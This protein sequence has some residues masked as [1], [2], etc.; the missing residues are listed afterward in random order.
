MATIRKRNGQWQ[1]QVR[2]QGHSAV[3]NT[4]RQYKDAEAW[5]LETE[6]KLK[7]HGMPVSRKELEGVTLGELIER[8]RDQCLQ[9]K[10]SGENEKIV[11]NAFLA[12]EANL[13]RKSLATIS[14]QDFAKYRDERLR[15]VKPSTLRR[16]LN[17]LRHMFKVARNE[18]RLPADDPLQGLWLPAEP[19]HRERRLHEGEQARL[20]EAAQGCRGLRQKALWPMLILLALQT[21][22]RRGEI[23]GLRWEDVDFEKRTIVVRHSK[24]GKT[25]TLPMSAYMQPSFIAFGIFA[26]GGPIHSLW[27]SKRGERIDPMTSSAFE[28][29]W[30][31]LTKR[32][33]IQGLTFHD[34]RHEAACRFDEA[35]L[36]HSE[37]QYMLGHSHRDMTSR[38]V[39]ADLERIRA[40]LD[41]GWNTHL[42]QMKVYEEEQRR[43]EEQLVERFPSDDTPGYAELDSRD[44]VTLIIRR[45]A[46]AS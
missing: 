33:G 8:Y 15:N 5:G 30:R 20:L 17:P 41:Q 12:R 34:L 9:R 39:H 29:A 25:R 10:R 21:A 11:L 14:Q 7:L 13:C 46:I 27:E 44:K 36:T 31:R 38:Y 18:W 6:R 1:V 35:G 23:F 42:A 43:R 4:F 16:E 22:L 24:T 28:Q 2:L 45:G 37:T 40:K 32:A 26:D 19:A 3:S